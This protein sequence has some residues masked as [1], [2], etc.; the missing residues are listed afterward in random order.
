MKRSLSGIVPALLSSPLLAAV[1]EA[2]EEA[3]SA[4]VETVSVVWVVVFLVIF[5]GSIAAFFAYLWYSEKKRGDAGKGP[6]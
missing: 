1:N 2:G 6:K 3:A 5:F 4:P